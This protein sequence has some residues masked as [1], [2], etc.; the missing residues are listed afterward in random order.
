MNNIARRW[1]GRYFSVWRLSARARV[2]ATR[3]S[4]RRLPPN[5]RCSHRTIREP[6]ARIP[7]AQEA[8]DGV[9]EGEQV[10][11]ELR[12]VP[13]ACLRDGHRAA[14]RADLQAQRELSERLP[15]DR[16]RGRPV[17]D[18]DHAGR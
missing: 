17:Q 8:E 15:V 10:P 4:W 18:E 2:R 7:G 12:C 3:R 6:L 5:D 16:L 1:G 14:Q 11:E 13:R 9:E